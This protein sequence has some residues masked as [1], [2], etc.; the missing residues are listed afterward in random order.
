[1]ERVYYGAISKG[2]GSYGIVFP[3]FW[4]CVSAGD[5]YDEVIAMGHEALQ[6]HIEGMLDDE[7]PIPVPSQVTLDSVAAELADPDEMKEAG[8]RW[9]A[10]V[11]ILVIVPEKNEPRP[12]VMDAD[13]LRSVYSAEPNARRFIEDAVRRQLSELKKSA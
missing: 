5:S 2:E 7:D 8:E 6:F 1:M 4:G 3:D 13:L 12:I 10:V 9:I 11:P